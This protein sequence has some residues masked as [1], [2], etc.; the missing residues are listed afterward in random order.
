MKKNILTLIFVLLSMSVFSEVSQLELSI[1]KLIADKKLKLGFMLCE[2]QND[3][4]IAINADDHFP[5]QSVYKFPI[6]LAALD[7]ADKNGIA[8]TDTLIIE[9]RY[10][11]D[12]L[13][14]P[15]RKKQPHGD[16]KLPL[17]EIIYQT[18]AWSDNNGSDFLLKLIGGPGSALSYLK[19]QKFENILIRNYESEIQAD[20]KVQFSNY[21]TPRAMIS[22]LE[23]FYQK[24]LLKGDSFDFLWQVMT[25]TSTGSIRNYISNCS[26]IARK[27][28]SS[29]QNKKGYTAALN[30]VGIW[31]IASDRTLFYTIF[32]TESAESPETNAEIIAQIARLISLNCNSSC[33]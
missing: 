18:I 24:Q 28:G 4:C 26:L 12:T 31:R 15:I 30:D 14:S 5:M 13:W 32:I 9:E 33:N 3:Q 22:L 16:I 29:G 17:S 7:Y 25:D 11:S 6:A 2:L 27:T 10:L 1:R 21:T 23:A 20:W 8:L 19:D